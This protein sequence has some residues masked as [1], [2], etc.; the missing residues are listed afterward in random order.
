MEVIYE[1]KKEMTFIGYH[2]VIRPDE[3]YQKC[4]EFWEKEYAMKY[5]KLWQTMEPANAV[6]KAI[7]EN[8]IGMYAICAE[9]ENGFSYWI[10]GMYQGGDVPDGL[11]L[12]SFPES[13]WAVFDTKG[14]IPGSLQTLN[15]AV[16]QEWFPNEGQKYHANAA[17]TLEVYS[18]G[19]PNSAE[20]ECSIWVPVR[21]RVSEY[22]AYCGLDCETCEAHI[23][24]V[25]DDNDLR[26]KVAKEWSELNKVEITPEMINCAGCRID[27]VKTPFCDSLCPIRQCALSKD[28]E[29]CGDCGEMSTCE[30]LEMI[31]ENN[32]EAL[33]RLKG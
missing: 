19:D 3:G 11:E 18:A 25:D 7:I 22:I 26:I 8:G 20:Y 5:A 27:G 23:A 6:E 31:T 24:T 17:V 14:P 9:A 10:A 12:Y 21:N 16:W 28:I 4:P 32:D 30:K 1:K 2:T 33:K 15:T 13:N 29:T